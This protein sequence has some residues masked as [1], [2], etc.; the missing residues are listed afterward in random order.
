MVDAAAAE[1]LEHQMPE[2][3]MLEAVSCSDLLSYTT[4]SNTRDKGGRCEN[5]GHC[6]M[7]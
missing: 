3:F 1:S 7:V 4:C 5:Q 6:Q 2:G